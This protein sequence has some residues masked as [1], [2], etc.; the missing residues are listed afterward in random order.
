MR[1]I[2]IP[3]QDFALKCR[4][5]LMCE[6]GCICG[7]LRYCKVYSRVL[8]CCTGSV[9]SSDVQSVSESQAESQAASQRS[10]I[11]NTIP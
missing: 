7:T 1:G 6:G 8:K 10:C 2:K 3:Q 4:G 9:D 5:E 11:S